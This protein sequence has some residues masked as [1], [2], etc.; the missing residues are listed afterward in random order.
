MLFRSPIPNNPLD[1]DLRHSSA[2]AEM[3]VNGLWQL[4]SPV[5]RPIALETLGGR[6]LAIDASI[7]MY[8]FQMAMR[9]RKTGD[10]LQGAHISTSAS[11]HS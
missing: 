3:G 8:Q 10:P 7:W 9:D 11:M 4:L 5:A 2:G 6:R 1:V